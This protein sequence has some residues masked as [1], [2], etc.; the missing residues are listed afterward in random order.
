MG[1]P[2]EVARR[3]ENIIVPFK[4]GDFSHKTGEAGGTG[5]VELGGL[6][7]FPEPLLR[8]RRSKDTKK[9]RIRGMPGTVKE[10]GDLGDADISISGY[11]EAYG[12]TDDI[13]D[14]VEMMLSVPENTELQDRVREVF[15]LLQ[16][17]GPVE[18][19]NPYCA[20]FDVSRVVVDDFEV[21]EIE[22]FPRRVAYRLFLSSDDDLELLEF[23]TLERR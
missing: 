15:E 23:E 19:I 22:R 4:K 2:D 21:N 12:E 6:K 20:A 1:L 8:I 7:L 5:P 17:A 16:A 13:W 14:E 3:I 9:T 18:I 10:I 11:F